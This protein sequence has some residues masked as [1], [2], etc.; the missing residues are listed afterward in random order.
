[1]QPRPADVIDVARD[2]PVLRL[3]PRTHKRLVAGHP[4][5]YSNEL[6][7]DGAARAL[8]RGALVRIAT[9][10]G[11]LLGTGMFNAHSLIALRLLDRTDNIAINV[12]WFERRLR[13]ALALRAK[14]Y[15]AP[16]YRLIHAEADGL[17][18]LVIDRF[19]D[20]FV[21]S[22][23]TAGM[24]FLL[25]L[26]SQALLRVC[27]EAILVAASDSPARSL[28]GLDPDTRL[29]HGEMS[30]P[31]RVVEN[32]VHYLADV[33]GGQKTG[34]F[35][36][37]RENRAFVAQLAPGARVLDLYC[38]TGGF[39]LACARAGAREV[40]GVDSSEPAL[41]LARGAAA[42][43]DLNDRVRF[44]KAEVFSFLDPSRGTGDL[45]DLVVADPP[46]FAKSRANLGPA[47]KGYRKL[48]R[49]A[50]ARVAPGGTLFLASCSHVVSPDDFLAECWRGISETGRIARVIRQAGAGADHPLHP[51]LPESAYLKALIFAL[52]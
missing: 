50:S 1:M 44:H 16:Y 43:N 52:D 14:L 38:Y 42:Q 39:A 31:V 15:D 23:G 8:A 46:A 26:L 36:D 24:D 40:V 2:L 11:R 3:K 28:E 5:V 6:E 13:R 48:A 34:W 4:W 41:A 18:G 35:Y 45:F 9:A 29:L 20:V 25:P 32:G 49:L 7:M 37:Q 33:F 47:L 22:S 17:P 27:A 21:I 12:D 19:G 51:A 30:G 10:D